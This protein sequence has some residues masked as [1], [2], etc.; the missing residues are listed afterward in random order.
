MPGGPK[1]D[2]EFCTV[3]PVKLAHIFK[4]RQRSEV[5]SKKRERLGATFSKDKDTDKDKEK[6]K[7][8]GK[9]TDK[10]KDKDKEER[11]PVKNGNSWERLPTPHVVWR[12]LAG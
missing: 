8:K 6:G 12:T 5:A 4:P 2:P 10:Y 3:Y 11:L 9:D 1:L 7:D